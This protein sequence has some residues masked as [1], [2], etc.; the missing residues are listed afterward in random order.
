MPRSP[1]TTTVSAHK[2]GEEIQTPKTSGPSKFQQGFPYSHQTWPKPYQW[3]VIVRRGS[4]GARLTRSRMSSGFPPQPS[5]S[6]ATSSSYGASA[7]K[8]LQRH[9]VP[10]RHPRPPHC[11]TKESIGSIDAPGIQRPLGGSG[12]RPIEALSH[13]TDPPQ[14][15]ICQI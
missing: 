5:R 2:L 3:D 6:L 7:S 1:L 8:S 14:S 10:F 12:D 11:K 13:T 15:R 9:R 4:S